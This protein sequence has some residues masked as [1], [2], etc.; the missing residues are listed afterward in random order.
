[1]KYTL[2]IVLLLPMYFALAQ[3]D[4]HQSYTD[5]WDKEQ[6]LKKTEGTYHFGFEDSVWTHW[7]KNG[8]MEEQTHYKMGVFDG[9]STQ[10]YDNGQKKLEGFFKR[11]MPRLPFKVSLIPS[12]DSCANC[13]G[14]KT[15]FATHM[16]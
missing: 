10:W 16:A 3:Q 13:I 6:T 11:N 9:K 5:Y 14:L 4:I 1:M 7:Y 2:L 8:K 15:A 12:M